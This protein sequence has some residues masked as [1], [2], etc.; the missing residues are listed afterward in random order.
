MLKKIINFLI[1]TM[2]TPNVFL[3]QEAH[4]VMRL[5]DLKQYTTLFV[6]IV[7]VIYDGITPYP[8]AIHA[9]NSIHERSG[10]K[11]VFVSNNPRP[12]L[13]SQTNLKR[14]GL[15]EDLTVVTSGD[16]TRWYLNQHYIGK[17]VYHF[18]ARGNQDILKDIDIFTT[19]DIYQADVVLLT[20]FL[21]AH[22]APEQF[23]SF[24][25][26]IAH[27]QK[28]VFCANPDE[29]ACY[30]AELRKCAGYFSKKI[31]G[32]GGKVTYLGKPNSE[33]YD[34]VC[35]MANLDMSHK[36]TFL[37]IGDTVET[38]IQGAK[39]F[40][41]DSLLVLT[42]ITAHFNKNT[43]HEYSFQPN[44]YMKKLA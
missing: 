32:F 37:M 39:N 25:F 3:H 4:E 2:A 30:G 17:T 12:S 13:L 33:F 35:M 38:D 28:P 16:Y 8:D 31:E 1:I 40:G 11:T 5:S 6:D 36:E 24:L 29:Y 42:G 21:E 27:S 23:D 22:E 18:G 41:I 43:M 14:M 7:G 15:I 20:Q 19:D 10:V 44:F 9:I 34:Y 26:D